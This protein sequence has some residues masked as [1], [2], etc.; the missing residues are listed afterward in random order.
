MLADS[1]L[2]SLTPSVN[3]PLNRYKLLPLFKDAIFMDLIEPNELAKKQEA[4]GYH[5]G[6]FQFLQKFQLRL[7][8]I[9]SEE[10]HSIFK[11]FYTT[12]PNAMKTTQMHNPPPPH[13]LSKETKNVI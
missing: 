9:F 8:L 10:N 5:K 3:T 11:N 13:E 12:S 4:T 6:T 2:E 1:T 7:N